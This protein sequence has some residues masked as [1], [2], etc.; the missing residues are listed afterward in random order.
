VKNEKEVG[1]GGVEAPLYY[2]PSSFRAV[3]GQFHQ[4]FR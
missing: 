1:G 3:S 2:K 4:Q